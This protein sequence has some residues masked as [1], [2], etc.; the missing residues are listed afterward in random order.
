[1]GHRRLDGAAS[2][3][4]GSTKGFAD[5]FEETV[6]ASDILLTERNI[7]KLEMENKLMGKTPDTT[8]IR[9]KQ[10]IALTAYWFNIHSESLFHSRSGLV[11]S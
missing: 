8:S 4:I 5:H 11:T 7:K 10:W 9:I 6:S 1:M 3:G 2:T